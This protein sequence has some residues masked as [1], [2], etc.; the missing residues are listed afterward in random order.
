MLLLQYQSL[1]HDFVTRPLGVEGVYFFII[2]RRRFSYAPQ[3]LADFSL[4]S[5]GHA[6]AYWLRSSP[7]T[8]L[9]IS[10]SSLTFAH[11]SSSV[12]SLPS[13]VELNPHWWLKHS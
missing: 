3:L 6:F 12:S 8:C 10:T 4:S 13:A 9:A 11:C 5:T 7:H 2:L 1:R